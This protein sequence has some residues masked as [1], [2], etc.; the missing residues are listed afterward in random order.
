MTPSFSMSEPMNRHSSFAQ[1]SYVS[2]SMRVFLPVGV[3]RVSKPKT[4][5]SPMTKKQPEID[6]NPFIPA[7]SP[8]C[9]TADV[10]LLAGVPLAGL[11]AVLALVLP[12][13]F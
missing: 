10:V 9:R 13:A 3:R 7:R 12:R 5:E 8:V 4:A 2:K 1:S 6:R 11:V